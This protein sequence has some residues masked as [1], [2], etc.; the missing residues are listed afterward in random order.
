[1]YGVT[2]LWIIDR[3]AD[4]FEN[5]WASNIGTLV[6]Q[7]FSSIV[8]FL[9][10]SIQFITQQILI[11]TSQERGLWLK[12]KHHRTEEKHGRSLI[13]SKLIPQKYFLSEENVDSE[14]YGKIY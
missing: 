5:F 1:M 7:S 11:K 4:R 14:C 6:S 13:N 3:S 9:V 12:S 10:S 8:Q 2:D